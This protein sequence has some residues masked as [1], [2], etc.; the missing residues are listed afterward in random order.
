MK[1]YSKIGIGI[2]LIRSTVNNLHILK[3]NFIEGICAIIRKINLKF[4]LFAIGYP[5]GYR[6]CVCVRV[7][8]ALS[9]T[10]FPFQILTCLFNRLYGIESKYANILAGF[11]AGGFFY[12]YPQ[13]SFLAYAIACTIEIVWQRMQNSKRPHQFIRKINELP[14]ARIFYP[15]IMGYLFH[16]RSF[17][18]WQTPTL[19]HKVMSFVTCRQ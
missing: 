13:S 10:K 4:I 17:Y 2:E 3:R 19:L 12:F 14:L 1:T 5:C 15:I 16:M 8:I 11:V 18:P 6:V 9:L 7:Q